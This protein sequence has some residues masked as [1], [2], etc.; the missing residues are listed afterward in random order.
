MFIEGTE[1][2]KKNVFIF[3]STYWPRKPSLERIAQMICMHIVLKKMIM[4]YKGNSYSKILS[5]NRNF[6]NGA[7]AA[8]HQKCLFF[9]KHRAC[10]NLSTQDKAIIMVLYGLLTIEHFAS[11]ET[12]KC[13][14]TCCR[15]PARPSKCV[16]YVCTCVSNVELYYFL[17]Q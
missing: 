8:G 6:G 17:S 5:Q 13:F 2:N 12:V 11:R 1:E 7:V 14:W 15:L 3:N 16:V 10:L 9:Y 4:V